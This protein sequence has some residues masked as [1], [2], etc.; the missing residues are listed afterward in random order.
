TCAVKI[1]VVQHRLSRRILPISK[2]ATQQGGSRTKYINMHGFHIIDLLL[3]LLRN[4]QRDRSMRFLCKL[5]CHWPEH[6]RDATSIHPLMALDSHRKIGLYPQFAGRSP[7]GCESSSKPQ[8]ARWRCYSY[9]CDQA[10]P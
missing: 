8:A 7:C 9:H 4:T 6:K 2:A 10:S 3:I 1:T 5:L